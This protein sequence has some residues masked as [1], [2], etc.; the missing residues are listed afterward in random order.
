M[1]YYDHY[2]DDGGDDDDDDDDDDATLQTHLMKC[3][4]MKQFMKSGI[5]LFCVLCSL[6]YTIIHN[7]VA[8]CSIS[9]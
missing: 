8:Q 5:D 1:L 2:H 7:G 4:Y 6:C 9:A 3:V